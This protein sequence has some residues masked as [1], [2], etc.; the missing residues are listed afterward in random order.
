MNFHNYPHRA[1]SG[2]EETFSIRCKKENYRR[3]NKNVLAER[4][5]AS[6]QNLTRRNLQV[7]YIKITFA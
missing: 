4:R 5:K 2:N 1:A 6:C 3:A 7:S